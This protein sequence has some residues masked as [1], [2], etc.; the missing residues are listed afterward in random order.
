MKKKTLTL[1][2]AALAVLVTIVP[3]SAQSAN[4]SV[5]A[6][7]TIEAY[8]NVTQEEDVAFGTIQPAAGATLTPGAAPGAGQ[9]LGRLRIQHNAGVS[10][11]A[12]L[13]TGLS[14]AGFP[15]LP[16]S[17][18]CG[19][20]QTPTGALDGASADCDA[21]P[22]RAANGDGSA[23]TSYL[24][25]GGSILAADTQD[26]VPGTYTGTLVFTITAVY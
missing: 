13:P 8:L 15:D 22:N 10:V 24:Q 23:R 11:S 4:A 1:A 16:V 21:L 26:R 20:S 25:I 9:S 18:S 12:A 2:G 7:A 6:S 19:F 3:A 17:F 5:D 14:L